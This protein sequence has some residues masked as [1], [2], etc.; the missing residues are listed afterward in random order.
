MS[1]S[2]LT[3][4]AP[5]AT[6]TRT[7]PPILVFAVKAAFSGGLL[8]LLFSRIDVAQFWGVATQSSVPWLVAA[9]GS[10]LVTVLV[11]S[12][13]WHRL[14]S[15]QTVR[16]P[17]RTVTESFLVSLFFNNFLPTNIGGDVMRVRDTARSAGSSTRAMTVVVADRVAGLI[18]LFLFA[19]AGG[20]MMARD[21]L[22]FS[23]VWI[24]LA[25]MG[26]TGA[27]IAALFVPS[28][29][30]PILGRLHGLRGGWV[31]RQLGALGGSLRHFREA[32]AGLCAVLAASVIIQAT[33][34]LFY[35]AVAR[36]LGVRVPVFEMALIV[37][38][39]GLIQLLPLSVNG[40]GVR[41]ATFTVL[42]GRVGVSAESALLISLEATA[43]ILA[44]S[45]SGALAY[46]LRGQMSRDAES[47][48]G[49]S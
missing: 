20:A 8:C 6:P 41:E 43:L 9:L 14:L 1:S 47:T 32:P 2:N 12:W 23:V 16:L 28:L 31:G 26:G 30:A 37:P 39:V 4:V 45:L 42:F 5:S 17:Y 11:S 22:P 44:F 21:Q 46:V 13:R 34:I 10:Y 35:V 40:F 48:A 3:A 33:F 15:I 7:I 36:S 27:S 24:W 49:R 25:L 29:F 38:L 18:G 19:A